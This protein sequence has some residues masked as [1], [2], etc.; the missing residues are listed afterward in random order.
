M[1]E[2][3]ER[4]LQL[5]FNP[6]FHLLLILLVQVFIY[7]DLFS[8]FFLSDDFLLLIREPGWFS[9]GQGFFRPVPLMAISSMYNLVGMNPVPFHLIS[10]LLHLGNAFLLYQIIRKLT[11]D[12]LFALAGGLL[13]AANFLNSEAVFWISS[14][15]TLFVCFFILLSISLFLNFLESGKK[16]FYLLSLASF[17]LALLSKEN[18]ILLALLLPLITFLWF[19][20]QNEKPDLKKVLKLT[21]PFLLLALVYLLLVSGLLQ[22]SLFS[23]SERGELSPGY[24]IIRNARHLFLSLV[25]SHPVNDLFFIH[26]D[27]FVF[28]MFPPASRLPLTPE[29]SF[30]M[31]IL[32]IAGILALIFVLFL[33]LKVGNKIRLSLISIFIAMGP[34]LLM[35]FHL[36][37]GIPYPYPN[38]LYYLPSV[39]F[40]IFLIILARWIIGTFRKGS[41]AGKAA[42]PVISIILISLVLFNGLQ[43]I[44]RSADW[45]KAG[46]ITKNILDRT[47][48]ILSGSPG[49][50][51]LVY[52]NLPDNYREA[53]IF[54]NGI[55]AAVRLYLNNQTLE[56]RHFPL[57]SA[58][59]IIHEHNPKDTVILYY[60]DQK[61]TLFQVR[62]QTL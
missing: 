20:Q 61:E 54:R 12:N 32:T 8:Q 41:K 23:G 27:Q 6:R 56:V 44:N 58:K 45:D 26:A 1:A 38:R 34:F 21:W 9:P 28:G 39:F 42:L 22:S 7:K 3:K 29:P 25:F 31:I 24:H 2:T 14:Q 60:D 4:D 53:F 35:K 49:K 46:I 43:T 18:G 16:I 17:I 57:S 62:P 52:V 13:L 59:K 5:I 11:G 47:R 15:T 37:G 40:I 48:L 19:Y 50:K 10:F 36:P 30:S 33:L 51:K 55:S